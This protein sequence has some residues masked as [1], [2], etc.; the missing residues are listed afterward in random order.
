MGKIRKADKKRSGWTKE[1]IEILIEHYPTMETSDLAIILGKKPNNLRDKAYVLGIKKTQEYIEKIKVLSIKKLH[2]KRLPEHGFQQGY[3]PWNKGQEGDNNNHGCKDTRFKKGHI[4][5][6]DRK[7]G[8]TRINIFGD[9]EIKTKEGSGKWKRLSRV[10]WEQNTGEKLTL[11]EVICFKDNNKKNVEFNNLY[12]LTK[13]ENMKRVGYYNLPQ[14]IRELIV[15]KR[16][17]VNVVNRRIKKNE[18]HD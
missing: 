14:E 9:I 8:E 17:F 6:N 18:Q 4:P 5:W 15:C 3:K 10:I 13:A 12:K 16:V 7:V 1:Q 2:A 11:N